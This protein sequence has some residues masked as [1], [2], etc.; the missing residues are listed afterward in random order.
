M[1]AS[2]LVHLTGGP[3][4]ALR[5][6]Q[7]LATLPDAP[8]HEVIVVDDASVGLEGLLARLEGDV[9][10]VTM[11]RRSGFAASVNRALDEAQGDTIVMLRGA[12]EVAH[13]FLAPLV[14]AV[15]DGGAG[16]AASVTA[17]APQTHLVAAHAFAVP[18][19]AL[20]AA[21][22]MPSAPDELAIAALCTVL[23][24]RAEL[25][26]NSAVVAPG[27]RTGAARR[28]PG[29]DPELTIVIPT[30]DA[31][32]ERVR[33][34][35]AAVQRCT[36]GPYELAII[37]NGAPPQGFT[38]PVNSGIRAARGQFVVV[39][40][41]DVEVLPG[42]WQPLKAALEAG[43]SVAFPLTVDGAM[44]DRLRRLV[45]RA[46]ARDGRALRGRPRRILR[47]APDG[48]VPGHR[49]EHPPARRRLP[50]GAGARVVHPPR[51]LRDGRQRR[52]GV[53][54]MD[55]RA[56][57]PRPRGVPGEAPGRAASAARMIAFGACVG[58]EE[59]F[60]RF[61]LP[62]IRLACEADSIVAEVTT[63]SSIF[64]AY[65]EVLDA[66]AGRDDLEALVLL[67]EDTEI[68]DSAFC[69]KVRARLAAPDIAVVGVVGARG[70]RSLAWWE[71]EGYGRV[72]ETRGVV[73]F[74]AGTHDVESVDGLMLVLSPWAVR[75]LRFDDQRFS[76]FHGYDADI[77][78]QARAAGKRVVVDEIA[79]V[80]HTK[81]GYGDS[82]AYRACDAAF[83]AKWSPGAIDIPA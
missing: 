62:G 6:F 12:P 19:A 80:H 9:S 34:C 53:A 44:R 14:D 55:Q 82:D 48:L 60:R 40:N 77:C 21:G 64:T 66:L 76:G 3:E 18:A 58:S 49:P 25:V 69:A 20:R 28:A 74:R 68:V 57:G 81:G 16:G 46:L 45:L 31:V 51:P 32:S 73:D 22:G 29:E 17:G 61:A 4:Q 78:F 50:A 42:W 10:I 83:V 24:G 70:V 36:E 39:M 11:D 23:D 13:G 35:V 54:R 8:E 63:D 15:T 30:L 59:Q 56:G 7:S 71:G 5:C 47:S 1:R 27:T 67:H 75:N 26:G 37:D 72:V 79:V 41:D 43:A 33:S 38:A 2:V 52:S 65:N